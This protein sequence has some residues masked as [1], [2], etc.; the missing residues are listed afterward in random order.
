MTSIDA[1]TALGLARAVRDRAL[2]CEELTRH[3]QARIEAQNGRTH[4]FVSVMGRRARLKARLWDGLLGSG[5]LDGREAGIFF[6]VPTAIKDLDPARGTWTRMGSRAYRYL[7]SPVDGPVARRVR[8]G[9]FVILGKLATSELAIMPVTETDIHP[10]CRNP[11]HLGHSAGGSS[12][13]SAA[14]VASGL[15]PLAH[16]SDGAG[17]IRIPASFCHLFGFKPSRGLIPNLY[18]PIDCFGMTTVNAVTVDVEDSAAMLDVLSGLRY[19]PRSPAEGSL[20]AACRRPL[21]R[22]RIGLTV[23]SPLGPV[24][25]EVVEATRAA[26]RLLADLGHEVVEGLSVG[27]QIM[28][29]LP[30]YG[31]LTARAPVLSESLLQPPSRWIRALGRKHTRAEVD[32]MVLKVEAQAA[33]WFGDLDVWITPTVPRLPPRIGEFAGSDGEAAFMGA[34]E[35]GAFTA[36]F[37]VTGQ[38]AMSLPLGVS[39]G[40]LPIG[41]QGVG[42]RGEDA[43]LLA[44]ARE[45]EAAAPW[46]ERLDGVRLGRG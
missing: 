28:E 34:A 32:A 6:G 16:A 8:D 44:L 21:R 14:A 30:I 46:R 26:A 11:W 27:G 22:L 37:N 35:Y 4:A 39:R 10:P 18:A 42:R 25:P 15:L 5:Q 20:L 13:G 24:D 43:L 31:L 19:D 17:S 29:F 2:S 1:L 9:G 45:L 40:G 36:I 33:A 12:G 41:V 3:F 38:P 23:R 7:W